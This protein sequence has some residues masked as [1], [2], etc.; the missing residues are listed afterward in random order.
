MLQ[1]IKKYNLSVKVAGFGKFNGQRL[2]TMS[3]SMKQI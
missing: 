3:L 2:N 1:G